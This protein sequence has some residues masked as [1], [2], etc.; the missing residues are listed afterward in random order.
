MA[1]ILLKL[2]PVEKVDPVIG[3][4]EEI[5]RIIEILSRKTKITR[6]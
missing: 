6:F 3:R 4:D 2:S 5:R 1:A